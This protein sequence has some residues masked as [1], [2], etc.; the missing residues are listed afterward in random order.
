M[1][2]TAILLA[3][4][5][6][7]LSATAWAMSGEEEYAVSFTVESAPPSNVNRCS[8]K[9]P[10]G[11]QPGDPGYNEVLLAPQYSCVSGQSCC[12]V[13]SCSTGAIKPQTGFACCGSGSTCKVS[14]D[15]QVGTIATCSA[16]P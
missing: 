8:I 6:I 16:V 11:A 5:T 14:E 4:G 13:F 1:I 12:G 7:A 9:C 10:P 15:P 3:L 2:R